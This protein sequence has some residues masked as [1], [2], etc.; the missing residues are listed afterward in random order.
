MIIITYTSMIATHLT[1]VA[2]YMKRAVKGHN[3]HGL[4]VAWLWHNGLTAYTA[5]GRKLPVIALF[6]S[7]FKT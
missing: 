3:P 5:A 6:I 7:V 1:T 4:L 2:A